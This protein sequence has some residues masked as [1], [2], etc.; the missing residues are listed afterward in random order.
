MFLAIL[1]LF[2]CTFGQHAQV[3]GVN[4][5]PARVVLTPR[6]A[7]ACLKHG[8]NPEI[9]RVRDL[10]RCVSVLS[11]DG[12]PRDRSDNFAQQETMHLATAS[13][14]FCAADANSPSHESSNR[15]GSAESSCVMWHSPL[16]LSD[17]RSIHSAPTRYLHR[18]WLQCYEAK[19]GFPMRTPQGCAALPCDS[20]GETHCTGG[21]EVVA[22]KI[23]QTSSMI[24]FVQS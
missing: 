9:L 18:V 21:Q 22:E 1:R 16:A 10:D 5:P 6:S 3:S 4:P 12:R 15:V 13:L 20:C 17:T 7:E 14:P 8:V 2:K 23:A 11:N 19:S 24:S